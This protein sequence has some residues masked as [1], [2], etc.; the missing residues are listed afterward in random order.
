METKLIPFSGAAIL[1]LPALINGGPLFYFD[2]AAYIEIPAKALAKLQPYLQAESIE[3]PQLATSF[4]KTDTVLPNTFGRAQNDGVVYSGRSAY[5]G[6]LAYLGWITTLWFPIVVQCLAGAWLIADIFRILAPKRWILAFFASTVALTFASSL[7]F[8]SVLIMPDVW[9]GFMVLALAILWS[10]PKRISRRRMLGLLMILSFSALA[11]QSHLAL[12]TLMVLFRAMIWAFRWPRSRSSYTLTIPL[13][14]V[15]IGLCGQIAFNRAVVFAYGAPPLARPMITA[16]LV[17]L[18]PGT[19]YARASCPESGYE[20]CT[21][22]DRLPT[23]WISFLFSP[24][25]R[26]GVFATGRPQTQRR[27]SAEQFD[28]VIGTLAFAP[29]ETLRQLT[30]E[31]LKQFATLSLK[32]IAITKRQSG[33]LNRNF[34]ADIASEIRASQIYKRPHLVPHMS[35]IL[36]VTT[37]MAA[38]ILFIMLLR[39]RHLYKDNVLIAIVLTCLAGFAVNALICGILAS[40][41]GR[42]QARVAWLLPLVVFF[43]ASVWRVSGASE[44]TKRK[45]RP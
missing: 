15:I 2:S 25:T 16:H 20:L 39:W 27:L 43:I 14:A 38:V 17:D 24:S 35:R 36:G 1:L 26:N 18:G 45:S 9:A 10:V 5:Y 37:A 41:Y 8:F 7:G 23:D 21:Y 31:G 12:L 3:T 6:A 28:F 29:L 40:P 42:F 13:L 34:P 22:V 19:I 32:D 30:G 11:H 4:G 33:F 44:D